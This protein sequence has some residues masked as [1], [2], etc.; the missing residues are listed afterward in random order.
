MTKDLPEM[1]ASDADRDAIAERLRDGY[2]EGR[3]TT[4]EFEERLEAA[5]ASRTRGELVPLVRD[6]PQPG[7]DTALGAA[8]GTQSAGASVQRWRDRYGATPT[9]RTG[10]AVMGGFVRKGSWI[11]PRLFRCF[12]LWG[13]GQID[14]RQARFED[15]DVEIKAFAIMGG[16]DIIVPHDAEVEVTGIGIMGGF[17]QG[18]TGTGT[19]GAPRVTV[20]GLALWGGVD[21]RRKK[22]RKGE[23]G[24]DRELSDGS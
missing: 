15:R 3:L 18:A 8:D 7:S 5:Y 11:M 1:R 4:E 10:I 2:A 6:L 19:A 20:S 22:P 23:R 21:V 12:T 9:S 24:E 14:L 13:G 17:E 16:I